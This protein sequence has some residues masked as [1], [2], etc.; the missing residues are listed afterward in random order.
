MAINVEVINNG[1][2]NSLAILRRFTKKVQKSGVL[3]KKRSLRY[4]TRS[5]SEYVKKKRTLKYIKQKAFIAEE[6]KSGRMAEK[7]PG[8]RTK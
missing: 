5:V 2:E 1:K 8:T 4:S 7:I 6:I 3:P